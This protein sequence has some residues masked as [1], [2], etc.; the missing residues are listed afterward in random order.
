MLGWN[1]R[2]AEPGTPAVAPGVRPGLP[3]PPFRAGLL[4]PICAPRPGAAVAAAAGLH[5]GGG[6]TQ[7]LLPLSSPAAT[8][9][10]HI[11]LNTNASDGVKASR[12]GSD[13]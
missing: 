4:T 2:A 12:A 8:A 6:G 10:R 11:E 13:F 3:S 1:H 7:A 5:G 9:A